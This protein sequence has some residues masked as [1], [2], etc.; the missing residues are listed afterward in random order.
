MWRSGTVATNRRQSIYCFIRENCIFSVFTVVYATVFLLGVVVAFVQL[1]GLYKVNISYICWNYLHRWIGECQY[2]FEVK[3]L[4]IWFAFGVVLLARTVV[5]VVLHAIESCSDCS[6]VCHAFLPS[7][8][9][10]YGEHTHHGLLFCRLSRYVVNS[11]INISFSAS[12]R[13]KNLIYFV[14][15]QMW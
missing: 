8:R 15:P 9:E 4:C 13:K 10:C 6:L 12:S 3:C 14:L 7:Q 2:R 5:Y 11:I 1:I